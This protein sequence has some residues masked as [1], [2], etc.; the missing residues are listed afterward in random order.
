MSSKSTYKFSCDGFS[1]DEV[2]AYL[3]ENTLVRSLDKHIDEQTHIPIE[4]CYGKA[5][6]GQFCMMVVMQSKH[7]YI[8]KNHFVFADLD[9]LR[10]IKKTKCL[11]DGK[12]YKKGER[13]VPDGTC[14]ECICDE[15]LKTQDLDIT[16]PQCQRKQCGI[17]SSGEEHDLLNR[18]CVPVYDQTKTSCCPIE[19]RCRKF[20]FFF[21]LP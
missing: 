17:G 9:E 8:I 2:V 1:D 6:S 13:I 5:V 19:W 20:L 18:G 11:F 12:I 7:I 15:K 14:H 3:A 4:R 10:K 21:F 16:T